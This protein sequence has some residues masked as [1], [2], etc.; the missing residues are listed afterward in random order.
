L[1]GGPAE[2]EL[3]I[4]VDF[5]NTLIDY[6]RVF[7]AAA[8][9]R[10]LVAADFTGSKRAVRDAIRRLPGGELAWQR[11]QGHVYGAGIGAAVPFAGAEIFL[12]RCA[13]EGVAVFIVSHKTRYGHHDPARVDLR[14]AAR[15]W[16][17]ARGFFRPGRTAIPRDHVFFED[18]RGQ[19]LARIASLACTHFI[20][21]L[22]EVFADPRFPTG[23]CRILFAAAGTGY[24][25]A[26]CANWREITAATFGDAA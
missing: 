5:D 4:G 23:V 26:V 19:K 2:R 24:A 17:A 11:L 21:D 8:R 10:G 16:L 18:D 25:D 9:E 6:D 1:S 20:D 15:Q 3:R 13:A 12:R 22:E 14:E 7:V